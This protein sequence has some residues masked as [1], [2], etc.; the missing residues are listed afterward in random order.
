MYN[1][2]ALVNHLRRLAL[3]QLTTQA[4][5]LARLTAN[6]R[7][8]VAEVELVTAAACLHEAAE[9]QAYLRGYEQA[10]DDLTTAC[11]GW[12]DE[13]NDADERSGGG[14]AGLPVPPAA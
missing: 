11:R 10:V 3:A 6:C 2:D 12:Q 4:Q 9:L 1:S 14:A 7:E 13:A 5:I 8:A